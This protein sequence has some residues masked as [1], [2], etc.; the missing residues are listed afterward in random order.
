MTNEDLRLAELSRT[1]DPRDLGRH[2][3]NARVAAG[4]TQSALAAGEVTAAYISRLEDGQRRPDFELL[5][6]LA[7]R[8][9]V[10]MDYLL[11]PEPNDKRLELDLAVDYAELELAGGNAG[12]AL[13]ALDAVALSGPG[14]SD[15]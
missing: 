8:A 1:I 10:S 9:G 14:A 15:E 6:R 2:L 13:K 12:A 7:K 4:L 5:K 11:T 3:R